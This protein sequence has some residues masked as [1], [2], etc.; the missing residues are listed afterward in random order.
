MP[1]APQEQLSIRPT[2]ARWDRPYINCAEC[3]A[4]FPIEDSK[5]PS[6]NAQVVDICNKCGNPLT[7]KEGL[8]G[9]Y[10]PSCGTYNPK[11]EKAEFSAVKKSVERDYSDLLKSVLESGGTFIDFE[12]QVA[13]DA[14]TAEKL[15]WLGAAS[16]VAA[17]RE[18]NPAYID[19]SIIFF[20]RGHWKLTPNTKIPMPS[21]S[22]LT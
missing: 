1:Q 2:R 20:L 9:G 11:Q 14:D 21:S 4:K 12:K 17:S 7:D 10:C 13:S 6:C 5:C 19:E 15:F 8:K 16:L 22:E 18:R 3:G